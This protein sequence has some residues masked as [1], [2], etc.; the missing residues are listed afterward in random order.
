VVDARIVGTADSSTS[1]E[2][3]VVVEVECGRRWRFT[4]HS[5]AVLDRCR[6]LEHA[7]GSSAMDVEEEERGGP[8]EL[9]DE[10]LALGGDQTVGFPC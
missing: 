2:E 10:L 7:S 5:R 9:D 8:S 3:D 1:S 6:S 4:A